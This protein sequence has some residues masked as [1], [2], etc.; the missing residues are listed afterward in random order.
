MALCLANRSMATQGNAFLI[1]STTGSSKEDD[2]VLIR[3]TRGWLALLV[4]SLFLSLSL[5]A[6][7]NG[8][9]T[10]F[11]P[12][13][14]NANG[15]LY[16]PVTADARTA[17]GIVYTHFSGNN[18]SHPSGRE[19]ASRGYR[20]FLLNHYSNWIGFEGITPQIAEAVDYVRKLP[21][22]RKV[23]LLGHSGGGPLMTLYQ[24][25]AENG[26]KVCNGPEK[27]YPCQGKLDGLPKAD[28]L[29]LLDSHLGTGFQQ[30]TYTDPANRTEI[31]ST[32][33]DPFL[34]MFLPKN[35]FDPERRIGI[36]SGEFTRKFFAAQ[37]ARNEQV[38]A[39]A[40]WRLSEIVKRKGKFSDDEP[41][42]VPASQNARLLQADPRIVSHTHFPHPL[43]KAD[44]TKPTQIVPS[45]RPSL[46]TGRSAV[47]ELRSAQ[48][49]TVRGFLAEHALRTTKEY[50]MTEDS[51]TGI[52]WS[53]SSSSAVANIEGISV[54][55]LIMAMSCHYFLVPDE[56]IFDHAAAKD[57]Q[58]VLVEGASHTFTPCRQE[59]GDTEKRLFDYIASW[60][61]SDG[62]LR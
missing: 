43:L 62:R 48:V 21:G 35:G 44:G 54:P 46:V 5:Q 25:L 13:R 41:L 23:V 9:K 34:D 32:D 1:R 33:R 4:L 52:D 31:W 45:V 61:S 19:L 59:Y 58:Y 50:N 39:Y 55:T 22:I 27:F 49:T 60:L 37:A 51:I 18:L 24:N 47:G 7:S 11:V 17:I 36:Y 3:R 28:G 40:R 10:T 8:F 53:S 14:T 42:V 2:L 29:V 57:K 12:L 38:I 6:Q 20:V 15:V 16:E 26:P 56:M 30:L